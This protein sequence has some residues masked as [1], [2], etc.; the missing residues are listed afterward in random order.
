MRNIVLVR[1]N[2]SGLPSSLLQPFRTRG[3][4]HTLRVPLTVNCKEGM[5][6]AFTTTFT[7]TIY[8]SGDPPRFWENRLILLLTEW[9]VLLHSLW[10]YVLAFIRWII[11]VLAKL[12]LVI[13]IKAG[14]NFKLLKINVK[15]KL[16]RQEIS[17]LKSLI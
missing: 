5:S 2:T 14:T 15:V 6:P 4:S 9:T 12:N 11:N 13:N 1:G 16:L 7:D 17:N 10:L 8:K 3:R